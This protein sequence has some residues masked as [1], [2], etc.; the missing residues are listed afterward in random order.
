MKRYHPARIIPEEL[1]QDL[2][3]SGILLW[4]LERKQ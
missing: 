4:E 1:L 2:Q 3:R